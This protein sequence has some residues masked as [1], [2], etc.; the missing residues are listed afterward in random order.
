MVPVSF[1]YDDMCRNN[2]ECRVFFIHDCTLSL[3]LMYFILLE[4]AS[5]DDD[6]TVLMIKEL[7]ETRIRPVVQEDGGDIIYMV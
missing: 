3:I 7:L 4:E 2:N 6:E 5:E 1:L